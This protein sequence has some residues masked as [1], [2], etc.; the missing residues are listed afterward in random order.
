M[1]EDG[2]PTSSK[3]ICS[4][5]ELLSWWTFPSLF[6]IGIALTAN[7]CAHPIHVAFCPFVVCPWETSDSIFFRPLKILIG[8]HPASSPGAVSC[9]GWTNWLSQSHLMHHMLW[10]P[11][12]GLSP[13][14][15]HSSWVITLLVAPNWP[16]YSRCGLTRTKYKWIINSFDL[17]MEQ[18]ICSGILLI[19]IQQNLLKL[20]PVPVTCVMM[21]IG[22]FSLY[23][24]PIDPGKNH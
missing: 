10:L 21:A 15:T 7:Y 4:S 12:P 2:D 18:R 5:A 1:S 16:Q 22:L 8:S 6:L 9:P 24:T 14:W 19:L 17:L 3:D 23:E 11:H 20:L 13:N